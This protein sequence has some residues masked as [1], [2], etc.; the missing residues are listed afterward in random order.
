MPGTSTPPPPVQH[1]VTFQ[2]DMR[3]VTAGY[4]TP[5]VNGTFNGW[6]GN[7]NAMSDANNDSIWEVTLPLNAGQIEYKF[8][9][10][11]WAIQ[12]NLMPGMPCVLTVGANTNRVFN[13]MADTVL[14]VV[15]WESCVGCSSTPPPPAKAQIDLPITWDDSA[16]VNYAFTAFGGNTSALIADPFNAANTVLMSTKTVGAQTWAGTTFGDLATPIPFGT[17]STT[18]SVVV[19]SQ[20][21]GT[22]AT[23]LKVEDK[24]NPGIFSEVDVIAAF[25]GG[26]DTLSFDFSMA[27]VTPNFANTYDRVSIFYDFNNAGNGNT[28]Y[29]D[30]VWFAP[31]ASAPPPPFQDTV[32][33]TINVNMNLV[34]VDSSGV[35]LAGGA[36]FGVPG[37]NLMVDANSDGTYT[38]VVRRPKGFTGNYT[39][40]NGNCPSW[41]CKENIAG[42]SC[43]NGQFNDRLM[44][45]VM[46]DTTI[47]TCFGFCTSDGTCPGSIDSSEVT[48]VVNM[49]EYTN[50]FTSVELNGT[51]NGWCGNCNPMNDTDNDGIWETTLTLANGAYEYK[52]T[53][54]NWTGQ[55]TLDP[56]ED[57]LCTITSGNFTNRSIDV[58]ADV[59]TTSFCW[60]ACDKCITDFTE[61]FSIEQL[62]VISLLS[63]KKIQISGYDLSN[64]TVQVYDIVGKTIVSSTSLYGNIGTLDMSSV[65]S[66]IYI[67]TVRNE[68]SISSHKVL[69]K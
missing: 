41:A 24:T 47:S 12:E 52:F 6:C 5:E 67:V 57:S 36:S 35:Y 17:G 11:A 29:A 38:I 65:S 23:R 51:F 40:T 64:Y 22:L 18:L 13:I 49:N 43:A 4:T 62:K 21:S 3:N 32:E 68:N 27:T 31:G 15:C 63:E 46:N 56:S 1:N 25:S 19:F 54:D 39:F 42:Q 45:M 61:E 2:V 50:P 37:D 59:T 30:N 8:A 26:W 9:A 58:M 16:N 33:I 60:E 53:Y 69:V 48:F 55:E 44:S 10:D 20:A 28:Y 14:P 66:G 7:C 34:T